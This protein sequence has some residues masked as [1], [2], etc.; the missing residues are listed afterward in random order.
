MNSSKFLKVL[1]YLSLLPL[2]KTMQAMTVLYTA[3]LEAIRQ[4]QYVSWEGFGLQVSIQ[5]T[6]VSTDAPA[7]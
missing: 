1:E 5:P 4:Y 3:H 6:L 2:E 7:M